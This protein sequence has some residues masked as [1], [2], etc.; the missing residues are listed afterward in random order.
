MSASAK[1]MI[2]AEYEARINK[3]FESSPYY[4]PGSF[5]L[6]DFPANKLPINFN[7]NAVNEKQDDKSAQDTG[8]KL[9]I[10]PET[11][12]IAAAELLASNPA[13]DN[14]YLCRTTKKNFI[15]LH[16]KLLKNNRSSREDKNTAAF[17]YD[18][19]LRSYPTDFV[20]YVHGN[21]PDDEYAVPLIYHSVNDLETGIIPF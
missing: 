14:V 9:V 13:M 20:W 17:D 19:L 11:R 2:S 3:F 10:D 16:K 7:I 15:D 4:L 1:K 21:A 18:A 5:A 6:T 12:T 8:G